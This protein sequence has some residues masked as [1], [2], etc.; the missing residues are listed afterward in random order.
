MYAT[1]H[2]HLII[3]DSVTLIIQKNIHY[4]VLDYILCFIFL[5]LPLCH[6]QILSALHS[7]KPLGYDQDGIFSSL[8]INMKIK[9]TNWIVSDIPQI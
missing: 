6:I 9:I 8:D 2:T 7:Q 3:F 4:E 1:G 5:L